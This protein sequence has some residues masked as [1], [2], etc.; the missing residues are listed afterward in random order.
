MDTPLWC[1]GSLRSALVLVPLS[2]PPAAGPARRLQH[3]GVC[4][5]KLTEFR[6]GG[7]AAACC[8]RKRLAAV[9]ARTLISVLG[10]GLKQK[11]LAGLRLL[12]TPAEKDR[13]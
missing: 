4:C 5:C 6:D 13:L 9:V 1:L 3:S 2:H 8:R 11:P 10:G 12:R 7:I